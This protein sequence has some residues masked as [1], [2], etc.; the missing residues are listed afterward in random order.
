MKLCSCSWGKSRGLDMHGSI[1]NNTRPS[2]AGRYRAGPNLYRQVAAS[3]AGSWVLRYEMA[4]RKRWMGLGPISVFSLKEAQQRARSAQQQI[5]TG[6]D[7]IDARRNQRATE[8]RKAILTINFETA[9]QAYFD[10]HQSKWGG[11]ARTEFL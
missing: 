8:A 7:P 10:Q 9:V 1:G 5:Y 3:G 4:G 2:T 11:K 6:I